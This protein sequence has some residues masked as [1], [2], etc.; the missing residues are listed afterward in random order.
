MDKGQIQL[1]DTGMIDC[2]L[3]Y[4]TLVKMIVKYFRTLWSDADVHNIRADGGVSRE[5]IR[6]S[7]RTMKL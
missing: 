4:R 6:V 1:P 3:P 2:H 5:A 7:Y